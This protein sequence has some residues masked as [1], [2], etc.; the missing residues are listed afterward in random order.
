MSAVQ[1]LRQALFGNP[2][3]DGHKPDRNGVIEAFAQVAA[4]AAS[5]ATNL[6]PYETVALMNA[7]DTKPEGT[8]AYVYFNNGVTDDPLNT[9]YQYVD[10]DW[11]VAEWYV[12]QIA[13]VL[14]PLVDDVND[15]AASIS[16]SVAVIDALDEQIVVSG[17]TR[18]GVYPLVSGSAQ[19]VADTSSIIFTATED[20][21]ITEVGLWVWAVGSGDASLA[22]VSGTLPSVTFVSGVTVP[23]I[24]ATGAH[25]WSGLDIDLTAGQH[26]MLNL[27]SGGAS[28]STRTASGK[29][30]YFKFPTPL[31]TGSATFSASG[32]T[33]F[34]AYAGVAGLAFEVG[35]ENL[36]AEL[37]RVIPEPTSAPHEWVMYLIAGESIA[38]GY[39]DPPLT[40]T[41]QIPAGWAKQWYDGALTEI[42]GDPVGNST[43][44]SMWPAFCNRIIAEGRGVILVPYGRPGS[45]LLAASDTGGG[46]W[47][48]AGAHRSAAITALN[49]AKA[50]ATAAG[51]AWRYGGT[52]L[53]LGANDAAA[54]NQITPPI[55]IGN[56]EAA[57]PVLLT[58]FETNA[59][60]G[61]IMARTG[62]D[63]AG[64][65]ANDGYA[66]IRQAQEEFARANDSVSVGSISAI[67]F[68]ARSLLADNI[69]PTPDGNNEMGRDMGDCAV[70]AS[71]GR[72]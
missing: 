35:Y 6:I 50:A 40:N 47:S 63:A 48:P 53:A 21:N 28:I 16:A 39:N 30:A 11:I 52:L 49:A 66:E 31:T 71:A 1:T 59:G 3:S 33:E 15:A 61:L 8:L 9:V 44:S 32:S 13:A 51:L 68:P 70:I 14:Q 55:T 26:L 38:Q 10:G 41:L 25:V 46:N 12:E 22:I 23:D 29:T 37:Q 60:P 7:D 43:G 45:T 2:P 17:I 54:L 19:F 58:Y 56:F 62:R 36:D 72:I 57:L 69:H 65:G 27:P 42:T 24:T 20:C 18:N 64:D 34:V 67:T 4:I 5:A